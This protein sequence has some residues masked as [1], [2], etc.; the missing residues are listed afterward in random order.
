MIRREAKPVVKRHLRIFTTC[1]LLLFAVCTVHFKKQ[2]E[3][4]V[5][6]Q[7]LLARTDAKIF[8]IEPHY[9]AGNRLRAYA[10]AAVLA[11]EMGRSLVVV[12]EQDVHA[13]YRLSELFT[14]VQGILVEDGSNVIQKLKSSKSGVTVYDYMTALEKG[15]IVYN[16]KKHIYVRSAF[17]INGATAVNN[18]L[19][20]AEIQQLHPVG[21]IEQ[22]L[23]EKVRHF[24]TKPL[25][26]A[27]IR[28]LSN[29]QKDIPGF[30]ELANI[31]GTALG[32]TMEYREKCH[33]E[34]FI[35]HLQNAL[36][37][38]PSAVIFVTSDSYE[39]IIKLV[40]EFGENKV[41]YS[42]EVYNAECLSPDSIK[43]RHTLC[44]QLAMVD[45]IFLSRAKLLFT[46]D[47]SSASELI[48]RLGSRTHQSGCLA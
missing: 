36:R 46:S 25:I 48:V 42:A 14:N 35:P 39:S 37:N 6:L 11:R 23:N 1:S 41:F 17:V 20:D 16:T 29:L 21:L 7:K 31:T 5:E 38:D 4:H 24:G 45:F 8:A 43:K 28:T 15:A 33:V 27:H 18:S 10:S 2:D 47:W 44:T 40:H 26:G 19:L 34:Y 13:K 9:G 12:W 3:R 30:K 22:L 32:K